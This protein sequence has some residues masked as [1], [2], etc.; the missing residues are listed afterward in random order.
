MHSVSVFSIL[1]CYR[2]MSSL[3]ALTKVREC[4]GSVVKCIVVVAESVSC[5]VGR[6]SLD[7]ETRRFFTQP[8]LAALLRR[9]HN[10]VDHKHSALA[11][12]GLDITRCRGAS[13]CHTIHRRG[14]ECVIEGSIATVSLWRHL[15]VCIARVHRYHA[16]IIGVRATH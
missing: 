2:C 8:R 11:S 14:T 6:L 13:A 7:L 1:S 16:G 15:I 9:S 10:V 5:S 3:I 4:S 12:L